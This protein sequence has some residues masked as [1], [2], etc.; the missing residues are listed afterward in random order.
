MYRYVRDPGAVTLVERP[1]K[2]FPDRNK[3][4][5]INRTGLPHEV[6]PQAFHT[7]PTGDYAEFAKRQEEDPANQGPIDVGRVYGMAPLIVRTLDPE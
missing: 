3:G 4:S 7:L 2:T 1:E 5:Q 6:F